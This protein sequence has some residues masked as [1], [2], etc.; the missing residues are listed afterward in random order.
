MFYKVVICSFKIF[1][2]FI[3]LFMKIAPKQNKITFISRQMDTIPYDFMRIGN[4]LETTNKDIKTIYLCKKLNSGLFEHIKYFMHMFRQM[5]HIAT[6]KVVVIDSYCI[7][8]SILKHKKSLKII[9]IWHA[10]GLL[11]KFGYATIDTDE[12][13]KEETAKLMNMHKNYSAVISSSPHISKE[14]S[15]A[16]NISEDK[17]IALGLPRI[18]FLTSEQEMTSKRK[19]ILELYQSIDNKKLNILYVPTFRANSDVAYKD[20]SEKIDYS[21]YNLIIKLHNGDECFISSDN[22]ITAHSGL[23]GFEFLSI[24]DIVISDYS[25]IIFEALVAKKPVYL[26]CYDINSYIDKR[27]LFIDYYSIPAIISTSSEI[28]I[29]SIENKKA[30]MIDTTDFLDKFVAHR[31]MNITNAICATLC[32]IVKNQDADINKI[33][34]NIINNERY[35]C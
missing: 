29:N 30:D 14:I 18:D 6:S 7:L 8:V 19:E 15:C 16:Y 27:G 17:V 32:E 26:Y 31:D 20:I 9:Q 4:R 34:D 23:T 1:M 3:Y 13:S 2:N 24:A 12:G 21:K 11:K 33:V 28:I 5:Y 22:K 35:T 10:I 25:A